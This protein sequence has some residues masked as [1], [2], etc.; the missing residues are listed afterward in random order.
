MPALFPPGPWTYACDSAGDWQIHHPL[1]GGEPLAIVKLEAD[2]RLVAAA[3][4]LYEAAKDAI[5]YFDDHSRAR[6]RA[7]IAKAEG[8]Y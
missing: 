4:D 5:Y 2:A 8:K 6:L 1:S 3:P 7:A